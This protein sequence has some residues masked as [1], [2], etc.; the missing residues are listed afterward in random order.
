[1]FGI[2]AR[3]RKLRDLAFSVRAHAQPVLRR[4]TQSF[5]WRGS[6][7][8]LNGVTSEKL[9]QKNKCKNPKEERKKYQA[10]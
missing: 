9:H 3:N 2:G 1:M 10:L 5:S 6:E 4:A 8:I 7:Y